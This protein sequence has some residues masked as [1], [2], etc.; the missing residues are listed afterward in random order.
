MITAA[1]KQAF[2]K[3]VRDCLIHFHKQTPQQAA[4]TVGEV[5]NRIGDIDLTYHQ[6]PFDAACEIAD[7]PL[8][9]NLKC[10]REKYDEL[11]AMQH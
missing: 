6:E 1:D 5:C 10:Y 4:Q 9:L 3:T 2:W 11:L 7:K 8:D